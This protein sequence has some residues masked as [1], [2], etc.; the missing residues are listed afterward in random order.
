MKVGDKISIGRQYAVQAQSWTEPNRIYKHWVNAATTIPILQNQEKKMVTIDKFPDSF[1]NKFITFFSKYL[2][3]P[4]VLILEGKQT[5]DD[6]KKI[7][8]FENSNFF[9]TFLQNNRKKYSGC[10]VADAYKGMV[11]FEGMIKQIWWGK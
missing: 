9:D 5:L 6:L 10:V 2:T 11:D 7:T 3:V 8:Q 1:R 4:L